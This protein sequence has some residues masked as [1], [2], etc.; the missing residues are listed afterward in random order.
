MLIGVIADDFTGAGDIANTLAKGL[1]GQ[2]GLRTTQYLGLPD[3]PAAKTV[4]AGVIALKS[5][6]IVAEEAVELS[7]RALAW[8][9]AQGCRQ[10]VF[11]YCSTFDSTPAGNIGPVAEALARALGVAGVVACPAFPTVGR[12]VYRGHLFVG[13]RLLHQSGL[14]T[15]PLNPM[16]DPDLRRWLAR[17]CAGP[18]GLVP[19]PVVRAGAA[20]LRSA[21][22]QAAA[23]GEALVIVDVLADEDLVVIGRACRDAPLVTGGSGIALGLPANL[24]ERG[25]ASG[26]A[27]PFS[28]VAGPEALLAG[29]CSG[30]TRRQIERHGQAHPVLAVAPDR[31]LDGS[32]GVGDLVDFIRAHEGEAPLVASSA[33]PEEVAAV[34]RRHGRDR[35]A[36]ALDTLFAETARALVAGGVRRLVVAG[37]ETSGAVVSALGLGVLAVG[38]EIDSGVPVLVSEGPDPLA[39]ALK[40]G[41]FGAP[42]F[43]AKALRK[44]AGEA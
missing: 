36:A 42:D 38:P 9:Q 27:V 37:G 10:V 8:L 15:H 4:E 32:I 40:S 31:V 21:L 20:A 35:V 43:F 25:L 12:T 44:L 13:D 28:G 23:R 2:G 33:T 17:Q 7:L 11:K 6:S 5:R 14:E 1:P 29:S 3:R 18:V 16:T 24:L 41:N 26:G 34:Q 19:W 39:L 30:A 22:D